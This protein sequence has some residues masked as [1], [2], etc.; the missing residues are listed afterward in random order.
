VTAGGPTPV[1]AARAAARAGRLREPTVW[2]RFGILAAFAL[3]P[4]VVPSFKVTDLA[5]KIALFATLAASYDIVI[6]YT[7]IVSFGHAMYFGFGAYAV[8]LALGKLG[9]V[10][11]GHLGLGFLAGIVVSAVVS[12][13]IGAF[14]LRVKALF[15]AM[16]TLAFAE[17]ALIL[18]V[19]WTSL[20]GGEDGLSPKLPGVLAVNWSGGRL[21]GIT[22]SARGVTYYGI[23][24]TCLVL[25][26]VMSRFVHSPLGRTLQAIRD[27]ELRAEALGYRT[28]VFQLVASSFGSVIAMLVGG[29]YAL[30]VR[31]VNPESTLGVPIMLDVLLMVII[32][33]LG[34]LYGGIVGAAFL[35]SARTLLPDLR[36]I[37]A[38]LAP[39]SQILQ[40]LADRWL[41]Y[42][43]VLFILVVFFFPKGVLGTLREAWARR[44]REPV[45]PPTRG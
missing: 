31:Y 29:L 24:A 32:G 25:F 2:L 42:F 33:G 35:L 45:P 7:G 6:G 41:L 9:G 37:G 38:A 18:A 13:L 27:N 36:A 15:F 34:T 3:V 21:L 43:G 11:Y 4:I 8:A 20:T 39:G 40:R 19:Q 10:T 12:A 44:T 26:L 14:S 30:W 16:I 1:Q 17:F 28:F 22:L 23:L 5:L